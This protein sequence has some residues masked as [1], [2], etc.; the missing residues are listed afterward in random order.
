MNIVSPKINKKNKS[1]KIFLAIFLFV[2]LF[3]G[4]FGI[5]ADYTQAV[6]S[7]P[8][9]AQK[10]D[11]FSCDATGWAS[12]PL[13]CLA[14]SLFGVMTAFVS[15][16]VTLFGWAID[17]ARMTAVISS[18]SVY[19]GWKNVRD[20]LNIAFILFLLFSAFCTIFQIQKYSYKSTLLN[21]VLMALLVNFS[22]PIARFIIDVSN[23][24][25]YTLISSLFPL[26]ISNLSGSL[27]G[28]SKLGDIINPGNANLAPL[29]VADIFLFIFGVTFLVMALLFIIRIIALAVL[30]IFSPIAFTGSIIPGLQEKASGWWTQLFNYSFF[31]PIM[32]FM[33]YIAT[34]LAGSMSTELGKTISKLASKNSSE[35]DWLA[36]LCSFIIPIVVLWLGIMFG[37]GMAGSVAESAI[38]LAKKGILGAG[39]IAG[40]AAMLGFKKTGVPGGIQQAWKQKIAQ[41]S[42]RFRQN[43][44]AKVA[45]FFGDKT[46][47]ERNMKTRAAEYEKDKISESDLKNWATKGDAA[48][49]YALA[50]AGKID[51]E[52]FTNSMKN[53]T[54]TKTRESLLSKVGD[55]RMDLTLR[56]RLEMN[57]A[58]KRNGDK[59][60]KNWNDI[61]DV[62]A[63]K[64]G[65]MKAEDW[66][67]QQDLPK[68][69]MNEPIHEAASKAFTKL[70]KEAKVEAFKRMNGTNSEAL[71]A[72][73]T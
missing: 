8:A 23:V 2:F 65:E 62:A 28:I 17:P 41:P 70:S 5:S 48:A 27:A 73:T 3:V 25:T 68:Q 37:K 19:L 38:G 53:I 67:K 14:Q 6:T 31:A 64:Y 36:N 50:N 71:G 24:L 72:K 22:F 13:N 63:S 58:K 69:F 12:S 56:H 7:V 26:G 59:S 9:N 10:V 34:G 16:A 47:A 40:G 49:V 32:I 44:E 15:L 29:I 55:T 11:E 46:A 4:L 33:L 57:D 60:A 52:T 51:E 39:A 54:D 66:A 18:D 20:F 45:G 43:Q 21:L 1:V 61:S 42:D 35:P 30:I